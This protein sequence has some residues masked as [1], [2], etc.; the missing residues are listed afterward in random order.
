VGDDDQNIYAFD[1]ASVEFIRRFA[2]DYSAKPVFLTDNYRSSAHI[3]SVANLIIKP[4]GSRMKAEHPITINRARAKVPPGGEWH[5]LDSVGKGRVQVLPGGRDPLSQ[6]VS[7]MI[8]LQRLS[9]LA[10]DWDWAK[11]AVIAREWKFLDPVRSFCELHSIPVQMADE[12]TYSL[13]RLRETQALIE[14]LRTRESRLIATA[15]MRGWLEGQSPGPWWELLREAVGEYQLETGGAELPVA[16]FVEWLAEWGR[17]VRRRQ[18]GLM[19][20]TAH[21]AKGLEFE[22]VAVLDGGWEKK[23]GR[24]E[25]RDAPRR[26]Y[27]VAVTRAEKTLLL[28]RFNS[29]HPLL[30]TLPDGPSFLRREPINLPPASPELRRRYQRLTLGDVD[31]GYAGRKSANHAV[32]RAIAALTSGDALQFRKDQDHW[33]LLDTRENII[34]RL[35]RAFMPPPGLQIIGARVAAIIIRERK[36]TEPEYLDLIRSERWEVVVPELVSGD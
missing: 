25:D 19:L 13:W 17:E 28:S 12:E 33:L 26:L 29:G 23:P 7:V 36:D 1:G 34:G 2:D 18:K 11:A 8:E 5:H 4:A 31:I 3:I 15:E 16:H 14:W 24:N 27:Y 32:H 20:L 35:A 30:D 10:Q 6:A 21:R 9:S 22:H